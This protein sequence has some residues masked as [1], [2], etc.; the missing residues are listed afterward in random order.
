MISSVAILT[1]PMSG[2]GKATANSAKAIARFRER[3][4]A[5]TELAGKSAAESLALARD[6]VAAGV[7]ALVAAGGDGLISAVLQV[8]AG[9]EV[10]IGIIP[11]GT[12][13]DLAREFGIPVDDA[14]AAADVVIEGKSKAIDLGRAGGTYFGT[15]LASGF[16]SRVT[17]RA[18]S[19]SWPKGKSRYNIAMVAELA[20]LRTVP[21]RIELDDQVVEV[22]AI[23]VAVGNTR[24]YGGGMLVVPGARTDD[25]MLDVTVIGATGRFELVRLMPTVYKGTHVNLD[26]VDTYR[27]RTVRLSAPGTTAYADGEPLGAL[28]IDIEAIP[29]AVRLFVP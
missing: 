7:E 24:S 2:H 3:G 11:G 17:D 16:D 1:N 13:N 10:P 8:A 25:G 18:N 5:V 21:Y 15:V 9:T 6:S 29:E 26:G 23:L 27:S 4:V 28:P 14:A 20:T 22:D 12:G 19:M